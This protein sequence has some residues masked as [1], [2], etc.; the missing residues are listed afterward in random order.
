M[1]AGG[2]DHR[3]LIRPS[4]E[5]S[6]KSRTTR[7]RFQRRLIDAV[8][9]ALGSTGASFRVHDDWGRIFVETTSRAALDV[10]PRVFGLASLSEI[11]AT[12]PAELS[13]IIETGERVYAERV[14]G[15]TFAVRARRAGRHPFS[16]RDINYQLG[17]ALNRHA[18]VKLK[19]PDVTVG[20][21]VRE[22]S[23]YF[24]SWRI[25]GAGG[26]P[27][28]VEGP[29]LALISGGYDSAVA[30]W[31]MLKRGVALDYVLCNL[32]GGAY[33]RAVLSVAKVLA[34]EW[35]YGAHPRIHII[36]FEEPLHR[37]RE[38][39]EERYW[40]VV[41]KRLMYRVGERIARETG[42]H[43]LVTG[44]A[45]GQVSSQTL[46][47]LEAIEAAVQIPILRPLAGFDKLEIIQRSRE[48]GTY[49]LSEKVR[50]HCALTERRPVTDAGPEAAE[51]AESRFDLA[52]LD[53]AVA[54]RR[55]LALREL[56]PS[57]LVMPYLY[58]TT[59][60]Q[61]AMVIDT[62]SR[63]QYEAWHYPGAERR[64]FWELFAERA[65]LERDGTYVLYCE[66]GLKSAQLA[67]KLQ[68]SGHEAYSF[69]G[70]VKALRSYARA[71]GLQPA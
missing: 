55:I 33:E 2:Y 11:E 17:A 30:A 67:E 27:A 19:D 37:L 18:E 35:S 20:V 52:L 4:G 22:G 43:A 10:L 60:P 59:I 57:E 1:N 25:R 13:A 40:Q 32:A 9:D 56:D 46:A 38:D 3:I 31:M 71:S 5:L 12:A 36:D 16:S 26:L 51:D 21:E 69:K 63:T 23:A 24:F 64:D 7:R 47:N 6:T 14:K 29:A 48:I 41:L 34:D 68:R 66:I 50:E 54:G 44:E 70:G 8:E 28:G 53:E 42:A 49:P 61:G 45:V 65:A 15:G 39:V 62:R 58:T